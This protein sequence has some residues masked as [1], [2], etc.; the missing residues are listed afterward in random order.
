MSLITAEAR[1]WQAHKARALTTDTPTTL[2]ADLFSPEQLASIQRW[3]DFMYESFTPNT[4]AVYCALARIKTI[5]NELEL[6]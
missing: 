6:V 3:Y 5:T 2:L 4:D 1:L